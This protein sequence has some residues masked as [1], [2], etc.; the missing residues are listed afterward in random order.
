MNRGMLLR[1][2]R[3]LLPTTLL[4]ALVLMIIEVALGFILPKFG[5]QMTQEWLQMDFARGIM[6]AMVG[7][8]IVGR[9]GTQM[10]HSMAW[11]H[12]VVLA[13]IW[14]HAMISGTRV[15]AAEVDHG[16]VDVFLS[17]PVSRWEVFISETVVWLG[18]GVLVLSAGLAG[19]LLGGLSLPVALRPVPNRLFIV[20]VN[21]FCLYLAA[22]GLACL[23]S[24]FSDRRGRALTT[25]F[26]L[27][28]FLFL[29]NYLAQF[30][31]PLEKFAFLSPLH[32][33]RPVNVLING[34][35]PWKDIGI[36]AGAGA[37]LW[38]C[39]GIVFARRDLC[40]V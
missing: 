30:W 28:L 36:L 34:T 31:H 39:G 20:M 27:L 13:L 40:T 9:M 6:Q 22:G 8:E 37:V 11:V 35:W 17:L 38:L 5:A 16:T 1:G 29:L 26:V 15:P 4:L 33:H 24:A 10:F 25:I 32:Y 18:C 7:A 23:V 19:N 12:P 2:L 21:L 14:A 3:E